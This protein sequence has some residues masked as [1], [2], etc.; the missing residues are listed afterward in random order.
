MT[1]LAKLLLGLTVLAVAGSTLGQDA[2]T[3]QKKAQ[4][5]LLAYR[6]ARVDGIRKLA[7]QIKG[8]RI[9]STTT[10]K[11][12]VAESDKIQTALDTF[13]VGARESGEPKYMEDGTC[14][15]QMEVT[16]VETVAALKKMHS[17]YYKGDKIKITDIEEMTVT[18]TRKIIQ[19]TGNGAPRSL[20]PPE[21][22]MAAVRE[23]NLTTDENMSAA[24]RKYW[25][26]NVTGQG[27]LMA[28][29]GAHLDGLRKLAER[30][31]GLQITSTT[32]VKDFVAE[33]DQIRTAMA[34][35]I[36]GARDTGIRYLED[37][38]IVEVKV[39]V[40]LREFYAS[41]KQW[42]SEF[43][44]GD[45]VK[46][47]RFDELI[48]QAKDKILSETGMS[49]VNPQWLKVAPVIQADAPM[50]KWPLIRAVGNA[51]MDAEN[52][53]KAQAKLMAQR[54][55]ELD[56]RRKLA[57][58]LNGLHI[59]SETT[60]RDFVAQNDEIRTGMLAFQQGGRVVEGST[61]YMEDGTVQVTVELDPQ[62]LADMVISYTKKF[63]IKLK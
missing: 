17:A 32:T 52:A 59:T 10:V 41:M 48:V 6:A 47:E 61:K 12:F 39:E 50:L 15:V 19:A 34:S 35:F 55:A 63:S 22:E 16:L 11:D 3:D 31:N 2:L 33:S 54:A 4:S 53:N 42:G 24:A 62:P 56:G 21:P 26:A 9:T 27:R 51:A 28:V 37:E 43:Y 30:I 40:T 60:V 14:E 49:V 36:R 38:P 46:I 25:L 23:G 57:E 29:R 1:K 44:K 5:K 13:L 45:K 8:L 20:V 58:E 7:E 18:N